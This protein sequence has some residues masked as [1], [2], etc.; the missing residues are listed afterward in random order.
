MTV[1]DL[2]PNAVVRGALFPE[3]VK[4]IA[5]VPMGNSVK[6]IG[7]GMV[8]G[9]VHPIQDPAQYDWQPDVKVEH[10]RLVADVTAHADEQRG[11]GEQRTS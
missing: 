11:T 4:V 3:A 6:L 2:K 8:S 5:V 10:Y 1:K 7:E 9:K